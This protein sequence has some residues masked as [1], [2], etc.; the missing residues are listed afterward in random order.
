MRIEAIMKIETTPG[1]NTKTTYTAQT[2]HRLTR[3]TD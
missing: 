1:G 3:P 2:V